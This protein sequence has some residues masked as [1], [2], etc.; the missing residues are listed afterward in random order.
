V[1][2]SQLFAPTLREVPAEAEIISHRLMLR[3]G[4]IRKATSGMY[5]YLPLAQKSLRKISDIVRDE[6][7]RAGGQEVGLP[8][9]QPAELWMESG[10]WYVYGDEMFRL[11]DRHQRD[12]CLGPTHEE[13]ITTLVRGEVHS[14]RQLPLLLYQI[15]NKYRDE[16]RPR[17]GLMRCREFIMKDLY[18]FDTDEAGMD[19]SYKKMHEA[20]SRIFTRLGLD[21]R[22]VEADS[23]AIGGSSSHEFM[24]TAGSG[25]AAIVYCDSCGYA[26]NVE[27]AE[28]EPENLQSELS[29][30]P[31]ELVKTPGVKTAEDVAA[32]FEIAVSDVIKTLF[33]QTDQGVIAVLI[34][35]DRNV[36]ETKL[37]N[38]LGCLWLELAGDSSV[39]EATGCAVG[40]VGPIGLKEIRIIADAEIISLKR[41]V[42]GAN[43]EDCHYRNA[44]PG[45]DFSW[46]T[47]G[48]VRN[49]ESSDVCPRCGSEISFARGI[50]VGHI[51]KLGSKYSSVLNAAYLDEKGQEQTMVMGCYGIGVSRTLAAAVEQNNDENGI[52][53]PI[54]IAPYHV[55]VVP[56]SWQDE[57][58]RAIAEKLYQDLLAAGI[59]VLLDDRNERAGVKFKDADLIG[60]PYRLTIGKKAVLENLVEVKERRSGQVDFVAMDEIVGYIKSAVE[61]VAPDS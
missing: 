42:V 30:M 11:R 53:W 31:L 54:P 2:I 9:V 19:I 6:M 3:A 17:F 38:L 56:V 16:R 39:K 27:K 21:Y 49:I 10:R 57:Q 36:N 61:P 43:K 60:L 22:V 13:I 51:F 25:E 33:Y 48:D 59:E 45:R 47:A 7:N 35:G 37:Q 29:P 12:F 28:T 4:M 46:N 40:S 55:T 8:I 18:S 41:A 26:A 44:Q 20:Y 14:Y 1:R 23:G 50:E 58:Q 34:R 15:Q 5:S 32:Y 24:V 52:I